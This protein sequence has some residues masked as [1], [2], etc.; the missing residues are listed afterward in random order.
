MTKKRNRYVLFLLT[1]SMASAGCAADRE[2]ADAR[3]DADECRLELQTLRAKLDQQDGGSLIRAQRDRLAAENE[4]LKR[5]LAQIRERER[6]LRKN[7]GITKTESPKAA[8]QIAAQREELKRA[9]ANLR[10]S[11]DQW[12]SSLAERQ[13]RIDVLT[14]QIQRLVK[15]LQA[16]RDAAHAATQPRSR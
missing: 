16:A 8:E 6:Q 13:R 14:H 1:V 2:L 9:L 12:E 5:E 15:E 10:R 7:L 11:R 3:L 4:Y